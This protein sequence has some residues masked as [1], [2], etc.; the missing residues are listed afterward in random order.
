MPTISVDSVPPG[1][2]TPQE[3]LVENLR[4]CLERNCSPFLSDDADKPFLITW[5]I[6]ERTKLAKDSFVVIIVENDAKAKLFSSYLQKLTLYDPVIISKSVEEDHENKSYNRKLIV[7]TPDGLN[8]DG[9]KEKKLCL[10]IIDNGHHLMLNEVVRKFVLS[11]QDSECRI[12]I[13]LANLLRDKENEKLLRPNALHSLMKDRLYDFP[14]KPESCSDLMSMLR[15]FC[16]PKQQIVEY[17]IQNQHWEQCNSNSKFVD[18]NEEIDKIVDSCYAFLRSHHYSLLEIYGPE[19]QDLIDDVPD[20]T[21]LPL[22]LLDDFVNIKNSLGLWCAERAALL[23][24]IKIDRLKTREKYERHFLLLSILYTEMVKVRKI[25]EEAFGELSDHERLIKYSTPRLIKLVEILRQFKPEHVARTSRNPK[26]KT[27]SPPP[28]PP[29]KEGTAED[30]ESLKGTT[31]Q[32]QESEQ[33]HTKPPS[34]NRGPRG[35][36]KGKT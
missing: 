15:F 18:I 8:S 33:H 22:K 9:F 27:V 10:L 6:K 1:T 7:A 30:E 17:S 35:R 24:I 36:Y 14:T 23:L 34:S 19:F 31:Q 32:S 25:C 4:I 2:F 26:P 28:L 12:V 5:L 11:H 16:S 20:P 29:V 21:E 13:L 3:N